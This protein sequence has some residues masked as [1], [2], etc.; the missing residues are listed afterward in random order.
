VFGCN[1]HTA[2]VELVDVTL[3]IVAL[4]EPSEK[5]LEYVRSA[6]KAA[7]VALDEI[8]KLKD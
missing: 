3:A 4:Y 2:D 1:Q 7:P 8:D 5:T 6:M